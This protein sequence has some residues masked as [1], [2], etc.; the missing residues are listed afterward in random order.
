[1]INKTEKGVQAMA[2]NVAY[3]GDIR[4]TYDQL[5]QI[6]AHVLAG[7]RLA[8]IQL[9]RI[10]TDLSMKDACHIV[11]NFHTI[12]FRTPQTILHENKSRRSDNR[13]ANVNGNQEKAQRVV[14]AVGKGVGTT[15]F[16]GG[17]LGLYVVSRLINPKKRR[18]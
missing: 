1:M 4:I 13:R 3:L 8:A 17:Y 15:A 10:W 14:K 16:L 2:Q 18:R 6:R 12:D 5:Q 7:E 9:I 11:D